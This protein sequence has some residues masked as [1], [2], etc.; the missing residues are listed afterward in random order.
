MYSNFSSTWPRSQPLGM[1]QGQHSPPPPVFHPMLLQ[2]MNTMS[3]YQHIAPRVQPVYSFPPSFGPRYHTS[4]GMAQERNYQGPSS[5]PGPN[6]TQRGAGHRKA[7]AQK[8]YHKNHESLP[9][10]SRD[11]LAPVHPADAWM[12]GNNP[13]CGALRPLSWYLSTFD[14]NATQQPIERYDL[15]HHLGPS[16]PSKTLTRDMVDPSIYE[17][18]VIELESKL[19]IAQSILL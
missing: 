14:S 19:I 10:T 2:A 9:R 18:P 7:R 11:P 16:K 5:G 13:G 12:G 6:R 1:N 15:D 8:P 17:I 4:S 3:W